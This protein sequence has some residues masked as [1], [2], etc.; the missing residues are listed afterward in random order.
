MAIDIGRIAY[1]EYCDSLDEE[2]PKWETI[3][4]AKQDA[5]RSTACAVLR[6]IDEER[7]RSDE[8]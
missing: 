5:W 2:L 4:K 8:D 7:K 3:G 6:Y 1:Q